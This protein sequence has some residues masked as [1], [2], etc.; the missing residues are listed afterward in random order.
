MG[1]DLALKEIKKIIRTNIKLNARSRLKDN[2]KA[3]HSVSFNNK[4]NGRLSILGQGI[5]FNYPEQANNSA[6]N[7]LPINYIDSINN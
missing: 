2:R 6:E 5:R 1:S 3:R 4:V 7:K